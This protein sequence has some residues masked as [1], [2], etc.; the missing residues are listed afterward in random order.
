VNNLNE[1]EKTDEDKIKDTALLFQT[2]IKSEFKDL[3]C[4]HVLSAYPKWR[5][6][7]VSRG[8]VT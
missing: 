2:I 4:Y 7:Y 3:S 5:A 1:S 8:T 6:V